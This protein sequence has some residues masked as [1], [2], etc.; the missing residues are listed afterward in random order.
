MARIE[1]FLWTAEATE[2][3]VTLVA[4][5]AASGEMLLGRLGDVDARGDMTFETAFELHGSFCDD[6]SFDQRAV[7]QA[8]VLAGD[9]RI[10]W[11]L[12]EPNGFRAAN[13]AMLLRLAAGSEAAAYF[14][15]VNAVMK[16]LHVRAEV[17]VANFDPLLDW[18]NAPTRASDLPFKEH[19]AAAAFS[20]LERWSGVT[21][22]EQWFSAAKPTFI[23]NVPQS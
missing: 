4:D 8:A 17:V 18:E 5:P 13:E 3:T 16:M 19:L 11:G 15:N 9:G 12:V 7:F 1:H 20:L 21:V 2:A 14:W 10:W 23:V 22:T 6:G